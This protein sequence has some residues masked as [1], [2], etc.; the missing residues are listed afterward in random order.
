MTEPDPR[1]SSAAGGSLLAFAIVTG[2]AVGVAMG[3]PTIGAIAGLAAGLLLV[4]IVWLAG[5]R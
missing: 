3:Q 1:R 2:A 4:L 5:R